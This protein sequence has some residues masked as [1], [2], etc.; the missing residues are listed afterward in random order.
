[1]KEFVDDGRRGNQ[2]LQF[3]IK[4]ALQ[5]LRAQRAHLRQLLQQ[6]R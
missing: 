4:D 1:M 2:I 6:F 5:S 3:Q